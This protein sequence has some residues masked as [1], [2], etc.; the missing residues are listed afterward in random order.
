VAD[1]GCDDAAAHE[2]DPA[3]IG[4]EDAGVEGVKRG[5]PVYRAEDH[6]HEQHGAGLTKGSGERRLEEAAK[7]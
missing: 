1:D 6:R 4:A 2:K 3:E 7:E 5:N